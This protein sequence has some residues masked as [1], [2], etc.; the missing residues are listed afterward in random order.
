MDLISLLGS[1]Y[2]KYLMCVC[3]AILNQPHELGSVNNARG[4]K[5][6]TERQRSYTK[7]S[8]VLF[9]SRYSRSLLHLVS[10]N[11]LYKLEIESFE[12][13]KS[14]KYNVDSS[15]LVWGGRG[16]GCPRV[17]RLNL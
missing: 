8:E 17:V 14:T 1:L 6:K 12:G 16:G 11:V 3:I 7:L 10:L 9:L 15:G 4:T 5:K 13:D 2:I